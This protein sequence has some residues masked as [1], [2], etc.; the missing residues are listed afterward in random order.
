VEKNSGVGLGETFAV[1]L[2]NGFPVELTHGLAVELT[3]GFAVELS[4]GFVGAP[5]CALPVSAKAIPQNSTIRK[6]RS[7]RYIMASASRTI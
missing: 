7:G 1:E 2:S 5:S 6:A 3:A 4:N